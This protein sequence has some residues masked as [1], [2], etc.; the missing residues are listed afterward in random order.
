MEAS[1]SRPLAL[2]QLGLSSHA[3]QVSA[4]IHSG[5]DTNSTDGSFAKKI[6]LEFQSLV[7]PLQVHSLNNQLLHWVWLKTNPVLMSL[8]N[9]SEL[10]TFYVIQ[11]LNQPL[12]LGNPW[13]TTYNPHIDWRTGKI[14]VSPLVSDQYLYPWRIRR[15]KTLS[16]PTC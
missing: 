10:L 9:H 8:D 6:G 3:V 14:I 2:V 4:F 11:S 13:L 7:Q 15:R 12:V 16:C 1:V 5:I